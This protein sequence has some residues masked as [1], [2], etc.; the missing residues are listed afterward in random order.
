M[1]GVDFTQDELC[2][3]RT[4]E[5]RGPSDHPIC[6][7]RSLVDMILTTLDEEFPALYARRGRTSIPPERLLRVS[8]LQ[9]LFYIRSERQ[10]A[11]HIDFN[12]LY[13]WFVGLTM[14]DDFW[15]HSTFST[16]RD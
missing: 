3:Y 4:L 5:S 14:D 15:E 11:E 13:R 12:L 8:L 7:L 9:I 2:S 1:R 6:K 16:N 10:L